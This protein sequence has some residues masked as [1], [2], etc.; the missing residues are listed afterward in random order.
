MLWA[1]FGHISGLE[2]TL[3][4]G[5]EDVALDLCGMGL[6]VA[7]IEHIKTTRNYRA[8]DRYIRTINI[9]PFPK[10]NAALAINK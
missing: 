5:S 10:I 9:L 7:K 8:K 4:F 1:L 3:P 6:I 2:N